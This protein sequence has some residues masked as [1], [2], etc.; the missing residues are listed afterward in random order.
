MSPS[1]P[2]KPPHP[3]TVVEGA[4]RALHEPDPAIADLVGE[5]RRQIVEPPPDS[6][7]DGV[8]A[9]K[10]LRENICPGGQSPYGPYVPPPRPGVSLEERAE[11]VWF[12]PHHIAFFRALRPGP[13]QALGQFAVRLAERRAAGVWWRR[14]WKAGAA[15]VVAAFAAA[16]W[17]VDQ[18]PLLRDLAKLI[19]GI[20]P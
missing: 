14:T 9:G 7:S 20:W 15:L 18:I 2:R 3:R 12:L 16:K 4:R 5:I 17:G 13:A 11:V 19:R 1:R 6:F 10:H 8:E